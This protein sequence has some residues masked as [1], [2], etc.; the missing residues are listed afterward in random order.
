LNDNRAIFCRKLH[1]Q[2]LPFTFTF[3]LPDDPGVALKFQIND[4]AAADYL[5][6]LCSAQGAE[7]GR[8]R[9]RNCTARNSVVISDS[10]KNIHQV[11]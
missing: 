11:K 2:N 7:Q 3:N 5:N 8:A 6:R 4:P 1:R 9:A 10:K